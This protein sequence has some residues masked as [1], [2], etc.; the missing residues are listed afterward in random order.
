MLMLSNATNQPM[1]TVEL[2]YMCPRGLTGPT[3]VTL[4]G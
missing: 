1:S 4:A 2:G 3:A